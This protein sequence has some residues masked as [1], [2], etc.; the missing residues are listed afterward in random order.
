VVV[1][2]ELNPVL[3]IWEL[4]KS[5]IDGSKRT[6]TPQTGPWKLLQRDAAHLKR[7]IFIVIQMK[8]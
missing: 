2:D 1:M 6:E 7:L 8:F 3:R 4:L 5:T